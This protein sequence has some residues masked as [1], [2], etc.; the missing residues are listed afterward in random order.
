LER[1]GNHHR[2]GADILHEGGE[3]GHHPDEDDDLDL[4]GPKIGADPVQPGLEDTGLGHRSADQKRTRHDDDDVVAEAFKRL[5][6]WN[7]PDQDG[8]QQRQNSDKI[9]AEPSPD[10]ESH[11]PGDDGEGE[12]LLMGHAK[13]KREELGS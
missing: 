6:C 1:D 3:H 8:D 2:Q 12:H 10:E 11:H 5:V 7:D 9:V 4:G 13:R